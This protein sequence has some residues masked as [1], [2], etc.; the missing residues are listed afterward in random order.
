MHGRTLSLSYHAIVLFEELISFIK[1]SPPANV[2]H[3][4]MQ[5]TDAV[6][7]NAPD[8]NEQTI[9]IELTAAIFT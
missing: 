1:G 4:I 5:I 8:L 2:F 9:F 6:K 7:M 3:G